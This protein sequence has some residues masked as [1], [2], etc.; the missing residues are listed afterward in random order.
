MP[1]SMPRRR[2]ADREQDVVDATGGAFPQNIL[3]CR[4]NQFR[5]RQFR[6]FVPHA[7]AEWAVEIAACGD[8]KNE[9]GRQLKHGGKW[10]RRNG[11]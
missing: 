4:R 3:P 8:F 6:K 5:L 9:M 2:S 7:I 1:E 10:K 11:Y